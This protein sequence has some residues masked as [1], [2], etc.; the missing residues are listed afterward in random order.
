MAQ[1][2]FSVHS[3]TLVDTTDQYNGGYSHWSTG[4]TMVIRKGDVTLELSEEEIKQLVQSLPR[5]VG[6]SY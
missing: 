2:K 1:D 3:Y 5:T 6:G 4:L